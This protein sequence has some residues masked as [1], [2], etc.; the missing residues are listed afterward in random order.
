L[1]QESSPDK[2]VVQATGFELLRPSLSFQMTMMIQNAIPV[3][4]RNTFLTVCTSESVVAPRRCSSE[5]ARPRSR[6]ED[7]EYTVYLKNETSDN[8]DTETLTDACTEASDE[9]TSSSD[10]VITAEEMEASPAP[11]AFGDFSLEE[12]PCPPPPTALRTAL[13]AKAARWEPVAPAAPASKKG[14]APLWRVGAAESPEWQTWW[15]ES[16]A[17]MVAKMSCALGQVECIS[18]VDCNKDGANWVVTARSDG[19]GYWQFAHLQ[20]VAKASLIKA[21]EESECIYVL[22]HR[23]M[24]FQP[25]PD[26]FGFVA[27]LGSMR[28]DK[29]ACWDCYDKG[30]CPRGSDCLWEH[31]AFVSVVNVS[32]DFGEMMPVAILM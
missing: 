19:T 21:A 17:D 15:E 2:K 23:K 1:N 14:A 4:E 7:L 3:I 27:S 18:Q 5:P 24:P 8:F 16:A 30:V 29:K 12:S 10:S 11:V 9:P 31:P 6:V 20:S 13:R 22:G 26:G 28:T 32:L 25:S